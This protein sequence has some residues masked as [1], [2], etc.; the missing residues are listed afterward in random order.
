MRGLLPILGAV[1]AALVGVALVVVAITVFL[2]PRG[3]RRRTDSLSRSGAAAE[4]GAARS[5]ARRG[6]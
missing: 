3:R 6:R 5:A 4:L 2:A 1:L